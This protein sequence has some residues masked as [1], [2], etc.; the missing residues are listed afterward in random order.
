[1]GLGARSCMTICSRG[2]GTSLLRQ[3]DLS[4]P[5]FRSEEEKK[6]PLMKLSVHCTV[7]DHRFCCCASLQRESSFVCSVTT[8]TSV[9]TAEQQP[10]E[11]AATDQ[12]S[13]SR[14]LRENY[15]VIFFVR[16]V[17][18]NVSRSKHPELLRPMRRS[19]LS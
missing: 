6:G 18:Y 9:S 4:K 2:S 11:E 10:V 17:F 16:F 12:L 8:H 15:V 19:E 14:K 3:V 5:I 7:Q 1:M 13:L